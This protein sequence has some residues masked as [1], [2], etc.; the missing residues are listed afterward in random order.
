M[1]LKSFEIQSK[2]T[3]ILLNTIED[4]NLSNEYINEFLSLNIFLLLKKIYITILFI[5]NVII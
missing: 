5:V 1:C 2:L 4:S 3:H